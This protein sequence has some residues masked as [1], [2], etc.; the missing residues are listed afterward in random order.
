MEQRLVVLDQPVWE[1][2]LD[3]LAELAELVASGGTIG[4]YPRDAEGQKGWQAE[5]K[6]RAGIREQKLNE[7]AIRL[8]AS[9]PSKQP[10]AR[11]VS[12]DALL[13]IGMRTSSEPP[14]LNRVANSV[15]AEFRNLPVLR[16]RDLLE[17]RWSA[18]KDREILPALRELV[19][20]PP[21]ERFDPPVESIALRR[22]YELSPDEG[23]KII[24]AE[25][26]E[27][28]RNLP[29]STLAMLPDATLPELNDILAERFDSLLILRYATADVVERIKQKYEAWNTEIQRQKSP[30]CAGP[31]VFYFLKYDP[32]FGERLLREDF[33]KTSAAPACYDIGFQ[34]LGLGRWAYSPALERLAI[35]S[36]SNP[37]VPVKRGAAEV[38]G[39][40]GSADAQRPLWQA[41]EYFRSWWKGRESELNDEGAQLERSLRIALARGDAWVLQKPDLLRLLDLCSTESCRT[42]VKGWI[43]L[44]E[45]G[46]TL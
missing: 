31:L 4:P 8:I 12:L 21:K 44:A 14:W 30:Y 41:M 9:L 20:N 35:E 13:N 10:N 23:R 29:F 3:A 36:L 6:R 38:L 37:K 28:K 22:L 40:Y 24:L 16:Q 42:E 46:P 33:A 25:I 11:A 5:Q 34:F 26:R 7:Y 27:P 1:R 39:K 19:A 2:Y 15:V 32:P 18:L 17:Y 45:A 43:A